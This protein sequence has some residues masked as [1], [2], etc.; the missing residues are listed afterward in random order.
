[1]QLLWDFIRRTFYMSV[2]IIPIPIG[3]YTIHNGSSAMVALVSYLVL[4]LCMPFF[5]LR[6]P[7]SGF[8]INHDVRVRPFAYV[9][10]YLTVQVI[11]YFA[12]SNVE[13]TQLWLL[14]TIGRDIVF[15]IVMYIQVL[16]SLLVGFLISKILK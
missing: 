14:P 11:T 3:S 15:I 8:G 16:S 10:G 7:K 1:M 12:F 2:F 5:Y 4:S 13:L 6:S 9:L